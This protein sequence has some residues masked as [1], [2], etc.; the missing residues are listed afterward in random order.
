MKNLERAAGV[1]S[2]KPTPTVHKITTLSPQGSVQN[3][4]L[5]RNQVHYNPPS[6]GPIGHCKAQTR[7]QGLVTLHSCQTASA[8]FRRLYGLIS[9]K[10]NSLQL[11]SPQLFAA[12]LIP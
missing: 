4:A 3:A 1:Q 10:E 12:A 6:P 9:Q 2:R 5:V 11:L 8:D 7:S